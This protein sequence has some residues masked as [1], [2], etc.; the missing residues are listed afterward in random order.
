MV[1]YQNPV[2]LR[3]QMSECLAMISPEAKEPAR[4]ASEFYRAGYRAAR[5][6]SVVFLGKHGVLN[7]RVR[8]IKEL[9]GKRPEKKE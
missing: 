4:A 1:V 7:L 5:V 6:N 3:N 9:P 2:C 8:E